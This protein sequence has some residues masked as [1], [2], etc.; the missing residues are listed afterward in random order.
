MPTV[1]VHGDDDPLVPVSSGIELAES[2]PGAELRLVP[3][4]GH[5]IPDAVV[6]QLLDAVLAATGR[7]VSAP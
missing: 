5:D 6:P 2:I 7:A 3:G 1:V 4:L